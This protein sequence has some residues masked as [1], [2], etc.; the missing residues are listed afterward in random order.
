MLLDGSLLPR[1]VPRLAVVDVVL[2]VIG[3]HFLGH[4]FD[5]LGKIGFELREGLAK[6]VQGIVYARVW[7]ADRVEGYVRYLGFEVAEVGLVDGVG[8]EVDEGVGRHD[9]WWLKGVRHF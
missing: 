8:E 6:I 7:V 1:V 2:R 3:A 4:V 9:L 5:R